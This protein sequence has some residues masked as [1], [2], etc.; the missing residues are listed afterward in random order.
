MRILFIT[1]P[2]PTLDGFKLK[3]PII[4]K[5]FYLII[6][7]SFKNPRK[8]YKYYHKKIDYNIIKLLDYLDKY[9]LYRDGKSPNKPTE[10]S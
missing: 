1:I 10:D 4:E 8:T 6:N 3:N 7:I 5:T 2:R 9:K